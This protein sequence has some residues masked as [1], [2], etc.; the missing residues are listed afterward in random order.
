MTD[1]KSPSKLDRRSKIWLA[2]A[3][4][5]ALAVAASLLTGDQSRRMLFDT[6]QRLGAHPVAARNVRVVL[7]DNN[8]PK[9]EEAQQEG[10]TAIQRNVLSEDFFEDIS[11]EGIGS[12]V[13]L[14]SNDEVNSLAALHMM[15]AFG[16]AED[17]HLPPTDE[18]TK[19]LRGRTLFGARVNYRL[20]ED[21]FREGATLQTV[22][23][24]RDYGLA[25]FR[26]QY[27]SQAIPLFSVGTNRSVQFFTV[28]KELR[29]EAGQELVSLFAP[30]LELDASPAGHALSQQP[31]QSGG[32]QR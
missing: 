18:V 9:I 20:L 23:L 26:S 30:G 1:S 19:E 22:R 11:L 13:A 32:A 7:I 29:P 12:L 3:M 6:W 28:E 31:G 2:W 14:T 5:A 10:L 27:G 15:E 21:W 24:T 16:R 4:L 17:Y 8:R 25:D